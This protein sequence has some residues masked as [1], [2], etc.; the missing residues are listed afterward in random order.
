[1]R[2][3]NLKT[4]LLLIGILLIAWGYHLLAVPPAASYDEMLNRAKSG[5]LFVICGGTC[6]MLWL[7]KR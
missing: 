1:M 3:F 5:V 6:M 4:G 2:F 7:A